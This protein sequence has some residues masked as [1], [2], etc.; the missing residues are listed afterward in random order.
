[1]LSERLKNNSHTDFP[2]IYDDEVPIN[3]LNSGTWI[4]K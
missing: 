2:F 4:E 3:N 1:M